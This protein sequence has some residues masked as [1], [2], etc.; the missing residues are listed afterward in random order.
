MQWPTLVKVFKL[1]HYPYGI[2]KIADH[3]S[4]LVL[5]SQTLARGAGYVKLLSYLRTRS[6]VICWY[7]ANTLSL[8]L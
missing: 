3:L 6:S 7:V 1:S 8:P 2:H 4:Y 5:H